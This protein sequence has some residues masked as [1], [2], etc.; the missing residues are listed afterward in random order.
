M[1]THPPRGLS[2]TLSW[3]GA[4]GPRS[5]RLPLGAL[6]R[7]GAVL[8]LCALSYRV[9]GWHR[10]LELSAQAVPGGARVVTA[11]N[12]IAPAASGSVSS[13]DTA[14]PGHPVGQSADLITPLNVR[15][16]SALV[17]GPSYNTPAEPSAVAPPPAP[18]NHEK[19]RPG[20]HLIPQS[21]E[22][23]GPELRM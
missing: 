5:A 2:L 8:S 11:A 23:S 4:H 1:D 14:A 21:G 15:D 9:G 18:K 10:G 12:A 3:T 7:V 6:A 17:M 13:V 19:P 16:P 22:H 20:P